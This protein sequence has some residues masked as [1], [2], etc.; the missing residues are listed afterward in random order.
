MGAL[1]ASIAYLT[2]CYWE[3]ILSFRVLELGLSPSLIGLFFALPGISYC[4]L[5][6]LIQFIPFSI[7]K[8]IC[9]SL[10]TFSMMIS[11]LFT[12]H[13]LFQSSVLLTAIGLFL[14][15]AAAALFLIPILPE[16][17]RSVRLMYADKEEE[18]TDV[19]SGVFNCFL[20][21]GQ[22]IS[23]IWATNMTAAVGFRLCSDYLGLI[24]GGFLVLYMLVTNI[25]E[26]IGVSQLVPS[27]E[28]IMEERMRRRKRF[29]SF[30]KSPVIMSDRISRYRRAMTEDHQEETYRF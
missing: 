29:Y 3:P 1:A 12:G 15:G 8:R 27:K 2:M 11:L 4:I 20:G 9:I 24:V 25:R 5:A 30:N 14:N 23:P 7:D 19:S 18:L 16:M 21:I 28:M 6:P 13:S 26:A 22:V 17:I 10:G